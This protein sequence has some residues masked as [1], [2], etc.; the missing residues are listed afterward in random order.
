MTPTI[1]TFKWVPPFAQ[2]HVRDI[3]ARWACEET[4]TPYQV[5]L[6]AD[7]KT[8]EYRR[9]VQ[10]F[11]QVPAYRDDTVELFESGAIALHIARQRPGLLPDDEAGRA[12]AEQ[13]V[14]A[15][16]NSVE[17]FVMDLVMVDLFEAD[18]PWSAM[19][20]PSVL[21]M[22]RS[23]LAGL[24]EALGDKP[25]LEGDF[26]V[27]DLIMSCVLRNVPREEVLADYPGLLAYFDR[28]LARPGFR[29][30]HA[31]Q[32]ALYEGASTPA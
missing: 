7:A 4:G 14:I 23:R 9:D 6:V 28:C 19:R 1:I 3:R 25:Y 20:R 8:P 11:G 26:S 10:P 22:L 29:K 16:L 13:W 27:G 12:R 30:A 24:S 32:M 17:P 31:D 5:S 2:G 21:E 15:A 18:K